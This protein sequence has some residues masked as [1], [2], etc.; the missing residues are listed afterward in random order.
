MTTGRSRTMI[1]IGMVVMP[2]G[3]RKAVPNVDSG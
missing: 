1:G 2:H 3:S